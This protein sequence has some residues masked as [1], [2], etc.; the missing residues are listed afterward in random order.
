MGA[1]PQGGATERV[2]DA[3][4]EA[5][6]ALEIR[7]GAILDKN[8]LAARFGVS[9]FPISEALNRLKA[10]GLVEIRPQS[11]STVSLIR[12][13]D[14]REN[15]FLRRA[16]E[17]ETM[18]LLAAR[19]DPELLVEVERNLRYQKAAM[20]AGDR[21]GFHRL[22]LEFHDLLVSAA[23]FSRVRAT[24]EKAR[25]ALDRARRLLGSPRRHALTF[26]EHTAIVDALRR[27][28]VEGARAATGAHIDSVME[29]LEVFSREHPEVFADGARVQAASQHM[30][31]ARPPIN[32]PDG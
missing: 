30:D 7:P 4:R 31:S 8:E 23:G 6:V 27:G 28:D 13:A 19:R 26:A 11:S 29:E 2:V 25:L 15:M 12:L 16:L 22:D 3:L 1:R 17:G 18:A 32:S 5:I 10:E 20:E 21:P 24:V 9:R 14:A